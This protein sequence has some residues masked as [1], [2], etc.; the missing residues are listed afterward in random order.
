MM[1][2]ISLLI[3]LMAMLG[4]LS[5]AM[6]NNLSPKSANQLVKNQFK[7]A[8]LGVLG[9][10]SIG[11]KYL[12]DGPDFTEKVSLQGKVVAITGASS[13]LGLVNA[14]TLAK[15]GAKVYMLNRDIPKSLQAIKDEGGNYGIDVIKCDLADLSS[16]KNA[17]EE[18]KSKTNKLDIL[19]NNAGIMAV[20]TRT[21]TKDNFESH[22]GVNHLAHFYLTSL[23]FGL[24]VKTGKEKSEMSRIVNVASAAHFFGGSNLQSDI[25]LENK[26]EKWNAYGN[27]KLANILFTNKLAKDI[28]K[29][30]LSEYVSTYSLHPGGCRT[31]LGRYI[32]D[33]NDIPKY[34]L[35]LLAPLGLPLFY[36]TKSKEK[37]AQ[38]QIYLSASTDMDKQKAYYNGLYFD[39]SRPSSA[40]SDLAK[41]NEMADWL[42]Q[43]SNKYTNSNFIV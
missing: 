20:P 43:A 22:I 9:V 27:S 30:G 11:G 38:C 41:S 15:L 25:F 23:L 24:L 2:A 29:S 3:V 8:A 32:V 39:N 37:G 34:A 17:A 1:T 35:P 40:M 16:V 42:W 7:N 33:P 10:G 14:V 12:L 13:G 26:Y 6:N 4:M 36:F 18:L 31:E 19:V 5:N 28:K 21:L